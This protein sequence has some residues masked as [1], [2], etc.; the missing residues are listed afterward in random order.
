MVSALSSAE[1]FDLDAGYI[2]QRVSE[3]CKLI[4]INAY[5]NYMKKLLFTVLVAI[6]FLAIPPS[7]IFAQ[8]KVIRVGQYENVPKVYTSDE[9]VSGIFPDILKYVGEQE[10]W[11]I[12]YV[13]CS[14]S[15]CLILLE[16]GDIDIM[17]DVAYSQERAQKY[18]FNAEP[19]LINWGVVY[20]KSGS[21]IESIPDLRDARIAV[22]SD[23]IH[24]TGEDGIAN[25]LE[26]FDMNASYLEVVNYTRVFELLDNGTADAGIVNR[27]FGATFDNQYDIE[28]TPIIINPVELF[29]AFPKSDPD[30]ADLISAI[31][32]HLFMLK[33]DA[34]SIY[35]ESLEE[36]LAPLQ[37]EPMSAKIL[38]YFIPVLFVISFVTAILLGLSV[39]LKKQVRS[40]TKQLVD[41]NQQ[42]KSS[43]EELRNVR[44][45]LEKNEN[46]LKQKIGELEKMQKY[47]VGREL[48]MAEMKKELQ[49]G[50]QK[51]DDK[52][53]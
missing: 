9:G 42:L 48:K 35:Y 32:E 38:K 8:Q 4:C 31:D 7:D 53:E 30:N 36:H 39:L 6:V 40:K 49:D 20:T 45:A 3:W 17:V 28:K 13:P 1:I 50:E 14:W 24:Y 46:Q 10:K 41:K 43:I 15:E 29:F 5:H 18:D 22:M 44:T 52:T 11:T 34:D 21:D 23:S 47:M 2:L 27:I 19:I 26:N 33:Q 12:E 37:K 25:T 16:E 51:G